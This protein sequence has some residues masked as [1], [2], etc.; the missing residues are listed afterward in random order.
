M[1]LLSPNNNVETLKGPHGILQDVVT[2]VRQF[3][4]MMRSD[5]AI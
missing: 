1:L 3:P 4:E 5:V 2:L